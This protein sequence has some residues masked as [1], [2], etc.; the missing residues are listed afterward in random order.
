MAKYCL[1]CTHEVIKYSAKLD[2]S[3]VL[4]EGELE[5]F[6]STLHLVEL[7]TVVEG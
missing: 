5:R 3:H 6:F 2:E 1:V 7:N 4:L